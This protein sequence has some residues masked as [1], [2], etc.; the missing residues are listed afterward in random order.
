M[1]T[2]SHTQ[3]PNDMSDTSRSMKSPNHA[4]NP[5]APPTSTPL[6]ISPFSNK[7]PK[8]MAR[9]N[10]SWGGEDWVGVVV[11]G[12]AMKW[13]TSSEE[14]EVARSVGEGDGAAEVAGA[15]ETAASVVTTVDSV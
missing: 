13:L 3:K 12:A 1:S 4:T 8:R 6:S 2:Q 14:V 9:A 15:V 7:A 11:L 5:L 10:Y